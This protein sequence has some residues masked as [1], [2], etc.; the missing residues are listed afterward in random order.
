MHREGRSA[1]PG[2]GQCLALAPSQSTRRLHG[3]LG[4]DQELEQLA[5]RTPNPFITLTNASSPPHPCH[6]PQICAPT[7]G[8][9]Q[10][11]CSCPCPATWMNRQSWR[12]WLL[13]RM[14]MAS[15]LL[16]WGE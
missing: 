11:W 12:G 13:P 10:C 6:P 9:T 7:P 14:W 5:S 4:M 2:A 16:T 8:W 15:T 1:M 3:D